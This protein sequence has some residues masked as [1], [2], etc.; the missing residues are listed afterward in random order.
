MLKQVTGTIAARVFATG[1]NLVVVMLAGHALG[2][3]GLGAISLITLGITLVMLPANLLGGGALV[4]LVPRVPLPRLLVPAYSCAVISVVLAYVLL[5]RVPLVPT[6]VELHVCL[7]A[8]LQAIYSVH[9]GVLLGDQRIARHNL[10]TTMNAAVLLIAFGAL[11]LRGSSSAM[12]F[13]LAS[14]VAFGFTVIASAWAMRGGRP[15]GDRSERV[16]LRFMFMQGLWVQGANG[17]QLINYRL[18]YKLI[19]HFQGTTPL[20]VYSVGNQLAES[21]WIAPRSLGMVLLSRVSNTDSADLRRKLT[22]TTM[23]LALTLATA[24]IMLLLVLPESVFSLAFGKEIHGLH[25]IMF[26]LAPGI[27]SM[28]ASQAFSHYF[29][30]TG[31]TKVNLVAS[32]FGVVITAGAGPWMVEHH[33]LIGAALAASAAYSASALY[34]L[35]VFMRRTRSAF[36]ELWPNA[37]DVERARELW[38]SLSPSAK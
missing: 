19:D 9:L 32:A 28:A 4:Y 31:H 15:A 26:A 6:G 18:A 21:A 1:M 38:R 17:L 35:Y 12:D 20:G 22:L 27:M 7:L 24:V 25:P 30:G 34:Q 5:L 3:P 2:A 8:L 29:S 11:I 14:Y 37:E 36:H 10:I 13:V 16:D 33:G 23:K